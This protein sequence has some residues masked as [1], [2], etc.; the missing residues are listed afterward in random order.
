MKFSSELIKGSTKNIILSVLANEGEL[1][2]Y[3]I[4]KSIRRVSAE[5]LEFG[6][7]S[8]YPAL[9]S[10][11]KAG[12]VSAHWVDQDNNAPARK[13]YQLTKKGGRALTAG[14]KE[15]KD[16]VSAVDKVYKGGNSFTAHFN[17]YA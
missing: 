13:Y 12:F 16:F 4:V 2:G 14:I 17:L 1:Y 5:S 6:E 9:H 7:G 8:I 3:Q 10:L 15:W 11:E